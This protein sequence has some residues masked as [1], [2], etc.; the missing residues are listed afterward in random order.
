MNLKG[1]GVLQVEPTDHCNLQCK[2]CAPHYH[3]WE[4][5]HKTP[6]GFLDVELWK[7]LVDDFVEDNVRFDH[8][9]FQWLGDPLIHPRLDDL[10]F[11]AAEKLGDLVEY[12]RVDT[13]GILLDQTRVQRILA[14]TCLADSPPLLLVLSIDAFSPEV[15]LNTKGRDMLAIVRQ[16]IRYLLYQR[17]IL[18][19]KSKLNVQ[20]QFVV[21]PENSHETTDFLRYWSD[22]M[23]CYGGAWHDEIMFKRLSVDGGA[24][25]QASADELYERSIQDRGITSGKKGNVSIRTWEKRPWQNDD[26]NSGART[27]CPGL[28]LTPVIRHDGQ[29]MMCCADLKG[30]LQLGSLQNKG[31]V[32]LWNGETA[33]AKRTEHLAGKFTGVCHHCGGINWYSLPSQATASMLLKR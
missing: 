32:E 30:E 9:I 21:Q 23:S 27:A 2:M 8:I 22:L 24:S 19:C 10:I 11:Y 3:G 15:Y 12:L 20:L 6:K 29:L 13:N 7:K 26:R 17:K 5:I 4:E 18:G 31:F 1:I 25:G 33:Q 16:N 14:A 28:W